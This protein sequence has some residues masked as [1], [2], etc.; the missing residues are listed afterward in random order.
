MGKLIYALMSDD[1]KS[2]HLASLI[3]SVKGI[4][5]SSLYVISGG[6]INA[7]VSDV[8]ISEFVADKSVAIDY[9][10]VIESFF[11]NF[12]LLP[13]R[14]GSIMESPEAVKAMLENN[15][16]EILHN[17]GKVAG[18]FE[19]G[20]K[21][22]CDSEKLKAKLSVKSDN[23]SKVEKP[24][25]DETTLSVYRDYVNKKLA[26]HRLEELMLAH[27][28]SLIATI[29][30]SLGSLNSINKFRKMLTDNTIV[31]AI[32]L[33]G[34]EKKSDLID[35]IAEIQNDNPGLNFVLTGPWP[36]YSFVDLTIK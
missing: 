11:F 29:T 21:I 16:P 9:A 30:A 5:D 34:K 22:I 14:F 8:N 24:S 18:K 33:I 32:F 2:G 27:V 25:K 6:G 7:I 20:L 15:S 31:D 23:T 19:F 3:S 35:L 13:M 10:N 1:A 28:E 26:E 17:L 12:S 36:P 4:S